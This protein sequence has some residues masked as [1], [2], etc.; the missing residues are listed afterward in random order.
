MTTSE[1]ID[2]PFASHIRRDPLPDAGIRIILFTDLPRNDADAVIAPL[3][4]H[5]K[6]IGRPVEHRI[7]DVEGSDLSSSLCR[8]LD[9]AS[10]PLVLVTTA[11]EPWTAAH[12]EPLLKA[13]DYCDHVVGRRPAD[14]R[15]QWTR[16]LKSLPGRLVFALP[17]LDVHSPCRLH[18]LEKLAAIPLQSSSCFLDKEVLAKATF[19]GHL[20]DE[21]DVPPLQG[22]RK[23]A[24]SWSD[25]NQIFRHPLFKRELSP[26]EEAQGQKECEEGPAGEDQQPAAHVHQAGALEHDS[27]KGPD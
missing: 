14:G 19:L 13:I 11:S 18:R 7:L 1:A 3:I 21:V 8:G 5:I 23:A 20:I 2:D 9:S 16:R 15:E 10:F 12:L 6:A 25:W 17:L 24:G 22:I 26:A 4:E 27:P